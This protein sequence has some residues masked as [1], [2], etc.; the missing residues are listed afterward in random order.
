MRYPVRCCCEPTKLYGVIE[1]PDGVREGTTTIVRER[2]S[3]P[4]NWLTQEKPM[5][6]SDGNIHSIKLMRVVDH[7]SGL[8]EVAVYSD[9]RPI[10]FWRKIIGF[11]ELKPQ[12][13]TFHTI[14]MDTVTECAE[15]LS[16]GR[17]VS[18]FVDGDDRRVSGRVKAVKFVERRGCTDITIE[19]MV[20]V[21]S[22]GS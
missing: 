15:A 22:G 12:D 19:E 10:E 3:I 18:V 4:A 7:R 20:P 1:L 5:V 2:P 21:R 9:D 11:T 14:S 8:D 6:T 17:R 13:F 16:S